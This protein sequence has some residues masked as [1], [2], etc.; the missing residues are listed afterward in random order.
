MN[1]R[2]ETVICRDLEGKEYVVPTSELTF[3]PSVYGILIKDD[4]VL[5]SPQFDGYDFP[6]GGMDIDES[7]DEAL[8]R[9]FW[10]ET[11]LKVTK[12]TIVS[13][14]T[15]FYKLKFSGNAVN[16]ILMHYT[17]RFVS[18]ELSIEGFDEMEK[19]FARLAEWVGLD[20]VDSLKFC[21]SVDSPAAIRLAQKMVSQ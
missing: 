2:K 5:L 10:E 8:E 17:V 1:Q 3:R 19:K 18:G 20:K 14:Q 12:D 6:G 11:G 15:S 21:N 16:A 13:C 7:I 4:K 9:E